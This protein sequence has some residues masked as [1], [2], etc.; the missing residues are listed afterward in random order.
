VLQ[1]APNP[2]DNT[3][4]LTIGLPDEGRVTVRVYDLMGR[5]VRTVVDSVL[6]A[7]WHQAGWNG[8][9]DSGRSVASGL[10]IGRLVTPSGTATLRMVK[11]R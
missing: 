8:D 1:A 2:F 10:Y 9:D 3:I 6:P 7:G 5:R 4:A 11:Q